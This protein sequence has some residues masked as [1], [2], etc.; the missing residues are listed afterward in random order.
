MGL[1]EMRWVAGLHRNTA[2]P[3]LHLLLNKNAVRRATGDLVY[4]PRLARDL[5]PHNL[6][7]ADGTKLLAAGLLTDTFAAQVDAHQRDRARWLQFTGPAPEA[8]FT[9]AV[10]APETLRTRPPT[11][12][13]QLAG[14]WLRAE[15]SLLAVPETAP[16]RAAGHNP[17]HDL[18]ILRTALAQLDQ[19]A[20]AQR[21]PV[22][23]AY[24]EAAELR[25]VLLTP[26]T[27]WRVTPHRQE[28]LAGITPSRLWS[29]L[30][31]TP[32]LWAAL[33]EPARATPPQPR[34]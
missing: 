1:A 24:L 9:R 10:L 20:L 4:V 12:V 33:P 28:P 31:L 21:Q 7:Q 2:H 6:R 19:T 22:A 27:L 11:P 18:A 32:N 25:S 29:P 17:A 26:A 8:V 3:H 14:R 5:L 30:T 23:P 13:E 15:V 16:A 34:R